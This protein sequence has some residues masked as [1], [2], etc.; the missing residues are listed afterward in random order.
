MYNRVN[1]KTWADI[2]SDNG[3]QWTPPITVHLPIQPIHSPDFVHVDSALGVCRRRVLSRMS[4]TESAKANEVEVLAVEFALGD[5]PFVPDYRHTT[6][7]LVKGR[8]PVAQAEYY[9]SD[10]DLLHRFEYACGTV[11]GSRQSVLCVTCTVSN[12]SDR[13]R[14]AHVHAKVNV[15]REPDLFEYHYIPFYWDAS[16]WLPCDRV[17]L[18]GER[19]LLDGQEMGKVVPGGFDCRWVDRAAFDDE[20]YRWS[21]TR[22]F[23]HPSMRLTTVENA[24]H[25]QAAIEPGEQKSFSVA[26]LTNY[27]GATP[28]HREALVEA[29]ADA[30]RVRSLADVRAVFDAD[31]TELTFPTQQWDELFTAVQVSTLQLLVRFPDETGLMPTQGG[32]SERHYVWVWEVMNTLAPMLRLGHFEPVREALDFVFSLQDGGCPP[33]GRFTSLAGAV[34]TTGPRWIATTGAALALAADY[35]RYAHDDAYL[36]EFLPKILR[37]AD[38]IMGEIR[39]T[40]QLAADGTRPLYYGLMPF[41]TATDGDI[42][43]VVSFSDAYSFRGLD[44]TAELLEQLGHPRAGEVRAEVEQYRADIAQAVVGLTRED[45]YIDRKIATGDPAEIIY[46]KFEYICGAFHLA[47]TRAMDIHTEAF[48]RYVAFFEQHMADGFFAGP[49]DREIMYMGVGEWVWQD[50]YLRLGEWKKAFMAVATNLKYGVT[51]DTHQVQERFSKCNPAFT[52]WQ[53]NASG[54]GRVLDMI[55]RSSYF[56][57][58]GT[59]TLL[60][61]VP[62]AWL[63][64]NGTTALGGLYTPAGQVSIRARMTDR[65][66]CRVRVSADAPGVLPSTIR[67]PGHFR[68]ESA[69]SAVFISKG[70]CLTLPSGAQEVEFILREP[71]GVGPA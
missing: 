33:S 10:C 4:V 20:A 9:L 46:R 43:Y 28:A 44:T 45:G 31:K 6:L 48:A 68:V 49:L 17:G 41:G 14:Q 52:P 34:G 70:G 1:E 27:E 8:Y 29:D 23:V 40:R 57:D 26:L 67:L 15:Q 38:W 64:Q 18:Q 66:H 7:R 51:H 65:T 21:W 16:K 50:I 32:S 22:N 11:D 37:G 60:G 61:G 59:V 19:I 30:V 56:E 24:L 53:P 25:F 3:F 36:A 54:N 62:F 35:Y 63:R 2:L 5:P 69:V 55:V 47:Y 39:A 12:E 42:G 71:E 13:T 58:R